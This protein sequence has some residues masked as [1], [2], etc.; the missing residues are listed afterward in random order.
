MLFRSSQNNLHKIG[1]VGGSSLAQ[2]PASMS[3]CT[4]ATSSPQL[5]GVSSYPT[6]PSFTPAEADVS[7]ISDVH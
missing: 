3:T 2:T 4:S 5:T 7:E 1:L 6:Y